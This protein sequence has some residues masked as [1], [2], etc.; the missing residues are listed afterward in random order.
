MTLEVRVPLQSKSPTDTQR[1]A[2]E[3]IERVVD[4]AE[5]VAGSHPGERAR[6]EPSLDPSE[7]SLEAIVARYAVASSPLR[8]RIYQGLG[9]VFVG[10][11]IIGVWIPGWPTVS[12]AVPAA[13]LFSL[14]SERL[15]RWSLTNPFFGPALFT[16]YAHGKTLPRHAKWAVTLLIAGMTGLS[17]WFV[18]RVSYPADPGFGP[19]TILMVGLAGM[20]YVTFK[21]PS[22]A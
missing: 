13:F 8:S 11:A 17:A 6:V 9:C 1:E 4:A 10:F 5:A 18:F 3:A 2:A 12:W 14:S 21:V 20:A 19:A 15:F 7:P 22:R 16:Y